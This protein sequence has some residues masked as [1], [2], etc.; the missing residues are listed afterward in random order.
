MSSETKTQ[1]PEL[2][3]L[4]RENTNLRRRVRYLERWQRWRRMRDQAENGAL[5][6]EVERWLAGN[7]EPRP[8]DEP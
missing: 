2:D 7:P 3:R 8:D 5:P 1:T 6:G 4:R